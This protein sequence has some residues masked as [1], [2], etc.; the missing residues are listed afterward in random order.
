MA[1]NVIHL[2]LKIDA[3]TRD[4]KAELSRLKEILG[5]LGTGS[6]FKF[7]ARQE[8][9]E[10]S[11]AAQELQ[12]HLSVATNKFG[13]FDINR[14][15]ASLKKGEMSL[16]DMSTKLLQIGP[17]GTKAFQTLSTQIL[18]AQKPALSFSNILTKMGTT[19]A[20]NIR[21]QLSS[22]AINTVTSSIREAWTYTKNMDTALTNIRVVTGKTREDMDKLA[23]SANKMAK[24]LKS[25]TQEIVKG[26]LI[27]YQQG[28][29]D[30][31]A[32]EKARI[33][34]MAANVS[35]ESSQEEMAE[36]LT[37]IWNSYKV[38]EN[39][40][41][42]FVDKLSAV[43]ATTATSMEEI[44]TGMQKVAASGNA[45]GVT[46][47]QLNATIATIS[48][49]T[50]TSAE[51]VG[52]ALKTIY[53]RMGDLK[54]GK[55]DEDGI[56]YGQV[57][58]QVKKL[59]FDIA[60]AN[61][62]LRDM[63]EVVEEIGNKWETLSRE[64]QTALAQAIAGKR[65]YTNLFALFENWDMYLETLE[66]SKNA[67]GT[68][69]EQQDAWANSIE[70]ASNRVKASFETL[71]TQIINDD[72]IIDVMN[73]IGGFLE[74]FT[75]LI[76]ALGGLKTILPAISGLMISTFA[77]SI[78][79]GFSSAAMNLRTIFGG[80]FV[81]LQK[82]NEQLINIANTPGFSRLSAEQQ[83]LILNTKDLAIAQQ[84]YLNNS[85]HM[86]TS[87]KEEA[88]N[89]ITVAQALQEN[90]SKLESLNQAYKETALSQKTFKLAG[91]GAAEAGTLN[92]G[93]ARL[94]FNSVFKN[95]NDNSAFFSA[96]LKQQLDD[97]Q[98][99]M[100]NGVKPSVDE[101]TDAIKRYN[102]EV[103]NINVGGGGAANGVRALEEAYDKLMNK[104][105]KTLG[106]MEGYKVLATSLKA[107]SLGGFTFDT[108]D[109]A[110]A[111]QVEQ[112]LKNI[113]IEAS[114]IEQIM[115]DG[116]I[117][118]G[119]LGSDITDLKSLEVAAEKAERKLNRFAEY[120]SRKFGVSADTI[121][122]GTKAFRDKTLAVEDYQKA[123]ER[124]KGAA[125]G[126]GTGLT[127][128][129]GGITSFTSSLVSLKSAGEAIG[130]GDWLTGISSGLMG[131]TMAGSGLKSIGKGFQTM[132]GEGGEAIKGLAR[133]MNDMGLTFQKT[134]S[135]VTDTAMSSTTAWLSVLGP[136]LAVTA[137]L[138]ALG[139]VITL[140]VKDFKQA[141]TN[142][143]SAKESAKSFAEDLSNAQDSF[144]T[145]KNDLNSYNE[146]Q[147]ALSKMT[148]GTQ[149]FT[150]AVDEANN[151]VLDLMSK[152]PELAE[153]VNDANGQLSISIEGQRKLL[154]LQQKQIDQAKIN[155]LVS[156][157]TALQATQEYREQQLADKVLG[158]KATAIGS[159]VAAGTTGAAIGAAIGTAILP[160]LGTAIGA[161]LGAAGGVAAGY[162]GSGAA[163][164]R[165]HG[166]DKFTAAIEAQGTS[167]LSSYS[168]LERA[169]DGDSEL[170]RALWANKE[171]T[172]N[173]A[174]E[175]VN[176]KKQVEIN[177]KQLIA[178]NPNVKNSLFS[179]DII[180]EGSSI[181]QDKQRSQK[182]ADEMIELLNGGSEQDAADA[183]LKAMYGSEAHKYRIIDRFGTN[184]TLQK[185]NDDGVW[186]TV[187]SKSGLS[188]QTM[189]ENYRGAKAAAESL[190]QKEI[191]Q[192]T[193][194]SAALRA[195][196]LSDS[197]DEVTQAIIAQYGKDAESAIEAIKKSGKGFIEIYRETLKGQFDNTSEAW[198]EMINFELQNNIAFEG[199]AQAVKNEDTEALEKYLKLFQ[200]LG[201]F[202]GE[203]IDIFKKFNTETGKFNDEAYTEAALRRLE[204]IKQ[205]VKETSEIEFSSGFLN[206][207]GVKEKRTEDGGWEIVEGEEIVR[208]Y[209]SSYFPPEL[210]D[211]IMKE[212]LG[213]MDVGDLFTKYFTAEIEKEIEDVILNDPTAAY[214]LPTDAGTWQKEYEISAEKA[215]EYALAV[216][217]LQKVQGA[218]IKV[219][220]DGR[221]ILEKNGQQYEQNSISALAWEASI[222]KS[223][224][225]ADNFKNISSEMYNSIVS[226]GTAYGWTKGQT[227]QFLT[228]L[229]SLNGASPD[230]S[231][232]ISQCVNAGGAAMAA[233][234]SVLALHDI[235]VTSNHDPESGTTTMTVADAEGNITTYRKGTVRKLGG[236]ARSETQKEFTTRVY[237]DI[238]NKNSINP[239]DLYTDFT[240][241][242][243]DMFSKVTSPGGINPGGGGGGGKETA[244]SK[245]YK[246]A[247]KQ[248]EDEIAQAEA[249][250]KSDKDYAKYRKTVETAWAKLVGA[251]RGL[252][253]AE[254]EEAKSEMQTTSLGVREVI[255]GYF[256]N[257]AEEWK[258]GY[259]QAEDEMGSKLAG[260]IADL[261]AQAQNGL[262]TLLSTGS[263]V[264]LQ[265]A[266]DAITAKLDEDGLESSLRTYLE[267]RQTEIKNVIDGLSEEFTDY[268][269]LDFWTAQEEAMLQHDKKLTGEDWKEF[270]NAK[271]ESLREALRDGEI[272]VEEFNK[273]WNDTIS[274]G[275]YDYDLGEMVPVF[276]FDERQDLSA[277]NE[278]QKYLDETISKIDEL[279][280]LKRTLKTAMDE[281][282][283]SQTI[284]LDTFKS[285]LQIEPQYLNVLIDEHGQ[286]IKNT[287]VLDRMIMKKLQDAA[288]TQAQTY[289]NAAIAA[290]EKG[291]AEAFFN[292]PE[293]KVYESEAS[294]YS[295]LESMLLT[296][297]KGKGFT[298]DEKQQGK[299]VMKFLASAPF[300]TEIEP[301]DSSKDPNLKDFNKKKEA[302]EEAKEK[303]D[304]QL[305]MGIIDEKTYR[306]K[307]K[308]YKQDAGKAYL[309]LSETNKKENLSFA[310]SLSLSDRESSLDEFNEI[311]VD[312][313]KE[314]E[315]ATATF[316]KGSDP[317]T[318]AQEE[319]IGWDELIN[320]G[321]SQQLYHVLDKYKE[322]ANNKDLPQAEREW[323][324]R[325]YKN[326]STILSNIEKKEYR[327]TDY[328]T[329][330]KIS[331]FGEK[332]P[333]DRSSLKEA[334]KYELEELEQKY[335]K[336]DLTLTDFLTDFKEIVNE[337]Y[338]D[339]ETGKEENLFDFDER[340]ELTIERIE[341]AKQDLSEGKITVKE[342]I[343]EINELANEEYE[344]ID[345]GGMI[346]LFS[347][348]EKEDL[349]DFDEVQKRIESMIDEVN[350]LQNIKQT[351]ADAVEELNEN[352]S[353]S[354]ATF[355][356]LMK[357][358][359]KYI[360]M[361]FDEQGQLE[362]NAEAIE[363]VTK[364]RLQDI[365]VAKV[366]QYI[367]SVKQA[368]E[369]GKLEEFFNNPDNEVMD[370]ETFEDYLVQMVVD[371]LGG[372][373]SPEYL[374]ISK[375]RARNYAKFTNL[376]DVNQ[377]LKKKEKTDAENEAK[378][379]R[380]KERRILKKKYEAGEISAELY[381]SELAEITKRDKKAG[382]LTDE[383][384][385]EE[386]KNDALEYANWQKDKLLEDFEN[387]LIDYETYVKGVQDIAKRQ[388]YDYELGDY[389]PLFSK[390]ERDEI[391]KGLG[392]ES[393]EKY[394]D[395]LDFAIE[396]G[397]INTAEALAEMWRILEDA[398]LT[399]AEREELIGKVTDTLDAGLESTIDL[400]E[401][402]VYSYQ[403]ASQK[404]Q[405][406]F[407]KGWNLE[408]IDASNWDSLGDTFEKTIEMQE[409]YI[410][411][412]TSLLES[413]D[414]LWEQGLLSFKDGMDANLYYIEKWG[415]ALTDA[416]K[417][418]YSNTEK[419]LEKYIDAQIA[420][421]E[422]GAQSLFDTI[423]NIQ[424]NMSYDPELVKDKTKEVLDPVL[425]EIFEDFDEGK[426]GTVAEA[427]EKMVT[428][429]IESGYTD[430]EEINK[431]LAE[432]FAKLYEHNLQSIQNKYSAIELS[433]G[434]ADYGMFSADLNGD[435][436][437]TEEEYR[438]E[439]WQNKMA[440]LLAL[441]DSFEANYK[442]TE[443]I[444]YDKTYQ[445]ILSAID[446]EQKAGE[447]LADAALQVRKDYL[448]RQKR[449]GNMTIDDE[450]NYLNQT[451]WMYDNNAFREY[452][453][454]EEDFLEWSR[455]NRLENWEAQVAAH[456][457][458]AEL[459][460]QQLIEEYQTEKNLIEKQKQLQETNFSSIMTLRQAQH[461]INK[462]LQN[463]LSMYEYLDE[464]TRKLIFNEE[465]Y[466][467][468]SNEILRIQDEI[469]DLTAD[470][471]EKILG[472][473]EEEMEILTK[474]YEAQ[475]ALKMKEYD[476]A[477]ANLEVTKKQMALQNTLNERNTR[478]FINGQW[479]WV[480]NPE[481]V[482]KAREEILEAE[483][484][485]ETEKLNLDHQKQMNVLDD[486]VNALDR[487]INDV[488]TRFKELKET[489]KGEDGG[490][491]ATL[492]E[493][494]IAL[495]AWTDKYGEGGDIKPGTGFGK[496]GHE[497]RD[498]Q[499]GTTVRSTIV[500][501]LKDI[502]NDGKS[503]PIGTII[504]GKN[505]TFV[506][507]AEGWA[508]YSEEIDPNTGMSIGKVKGATGKAKLYSD[509]YVK[510]S[511]LKNI[512]SMTDEE[513]ISFYN[514]FFGRT[515]N[516]DDNQPY[517]EASKYSKPYENDVTNYLQDI[518]NILLSLDS[519]NID[520]LKAYK[521]AID[522]AKN[523]AGAV[524][525]IGGKNFVSQG[526]GNFYSPDAD[527][528]FTAEEI[529][530][531]IDANITILRGTQGTEEAQWG[532]EKENYFPK[533]T[534]EEE[535]STKFPFVR[536]GEKFNSNEETSIPISLTD[537]D[538]NG[539]LATFDETVSDSITTTGASIVTAIEETGED[540]D[541]ITPDQNAYGNIINRPTLSWVGEDGPEAII[542]LSQKY[543]SRGLSL[544]EEATKALG[545]TPSFTM[546][547]IRASFPQQK[548]N[549]NVSQTIN[550]TVQ[551][552]DS[553]NDFYAITNLL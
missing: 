430:M 377:D 386:L 19:L 308:P 155:S 25:T 328:T 466:V 77:P 329:G 540:G 473:S 154:E 405:E 239:K 92:Y 331:I 297:W 91:N 256:D 142:M 349:K 112:A 304:Y 99:K 528:M 299:G 279:V 164:K 265:A 316:G 419:Q 22:A 162:F 50:R 383:E 126:F 447:Q 31:L 305:Q 406:M 253:E 518:I 472:A 55:T 173:L 465:D 434:V 295:F 1:N 184:S 481:S 362:L 48:S 451:Q 72:A 387:G 269:I 551:N 121:K 384:A 135:L 46:Y 117:P 480:A 156:K 433:Q 165:E 222:N 476:I 196:I 242:W 232:F 106:I 179:S 499:N 69:Q 176:N 84:E 98:T 244:A 129:V 396:Q 217:D 458:K 361:L 185:Q 301:I 144:N 223:I 285:L 17:D 271:L 464:E 109:I 538:N 114:V 86:T 515:Y 441:K 510:S 310:H 462:E 157:N 42:L 509:S 344:D 397:G 424:N 429:I 550:V 219:A 524:V 228:S 302:Y 170:A 423:A 455:K 119:V 195:K 313:R 88:Q 496:E 180:N 167:I 541:D 512:N 516:P 532:L 85:R 159:S 542:P 408:S 64:E 287:E 452:F 314:G 53:A 375:T 291:E 392:K 87:Q 115:R 215:K 371:D 388:Y 8:I 393:I 66:T 255:V 294:L 482:A 147:S 151:Q 146:K 62:Q 454:N 457:R 390:E 527:K 507:T 374:E 75:G 381:Y 214:S 274:K 275:Y 553:S 306:E 453:A 205:K 467:A 435:G 448:D 276:S 182:Y 243:T 484:N 317:Y 321:S 533:K 529:I 263:S 368:H 257:I 548:E 143:K 504:K 67:M 338:K 497:A 260:S 227:N 190:T 425:A 34:T 347:D 422:K 389:L 261:E 500:S 123:L 413:T 47:D 39:Q 333:I 495:A 102:S 350:E 81:D 398:T 323:N 83:K 187:G 468:L 110:V 326:L 210:I 288:I 293:S 420:L 44:A 89:A 353:I 240:S 6:G 130:Q 246:A 30:K 124:A 166:L 168:S 218:Q 28:D 188:D 76:E 506:N 216:Q 202:I 237:K 400:A 120:G 517:T 543:R 292:S 442:G 486:S 478:M 446:A 161:A 319:S 471:N 395:S 2:G 103:R 150:D 348:E 15:T 502:L 372:W 209:L 207:E 14:F 539:K 96:G 421:Y 352:N 148:K 262:M 485:A 32:A 264:D 258:E 508:E 521:T 427:A 437:F 513:L 469:N 79:S 403:E 94:T 536:T 37:A 140:V 531:K 273:E 526:D 141:E 231:G 192:I 12:K 490:V 277:F 248:Y 250:F 436:L 51:Q 68:L 479:T 483:Y 268:D 330:N 254:K 125:A 351:L 325:Q 107:N 127:K 259:K 220:E 519:T 234:N 82:S 212:Y 134:G 280:G 364:K 178:N 33:A 191:A 514:D 56:T 523:T 132:H 128:A 358:E 213:G 199:L 35:F 535:K 201:F 175:I 41:E 200:E 359:P 354:V 505:K 444:I 534:E 252:S 363:Q 29:S 11:I 186:E 432:Q 36:Y 373:V 43:G 229:N 172:N 503:V 230:L 546:P 5:Q 21:W 152:Y 410:E 61:G 346:P 307:M 45:V 52:T 80:W 208:S 206:L 57:S 416:Q 203:D 113:G 428:A 378:E 488:E 356:E 267:R 3:D 122:S 58:A 247:K 74:Y 198:Q 224:L 401:K 399:E 197:K 380:E 241:E 13:D 105:S 27:F 394:F 522:N 278:L 324:E 118:D 311:V 97:L 73:G 245:A 225:A 470:Y 4:A 266:Y 376:T 290:K 171:E 402:G 501:E 233:L 181:L 160:G 489:L 367:Q 108:K 379:A 475:V 71:Y 38:G 463:S 443:A 204:K 365:A 450:I 183:Y 417:N 366:Q 492:D 226:V 438:L 300:S 289:I 477:K 235:T 303:Y 26:Q 249:E 145:L 270:F 283:E 320:N 404:M 193:E 322:N 334:R 414:S 547:T 439:L 520:V 370:P 286:I 525:R 342:Y 411:Y 327:A 456:E 153:Y 138:V 189:I 343:D 440:E 345:L 139:A 9:R 409:K 498:K 487:Q 90:I 461:D 163:N 78:V 357:L 415:I 407:L 549:M 149:E 238:I 95:V 272:S 312:R 60:N 460:K 131:L 449:L 385:S 491:I 426:I 236:Y 537:L 101:L 40:L 544:W 111:K 445:S 7:N 194:K 133:S 355:G 18:N 412:A 136:I 493:F 494:D 431:I 511:V 284:S 530:G 211:Q 382:I 340:K 336:G 298:W 23:I 59:G 116:V 369:E 10:A 63:G 93:S 177:T 545:I 251:F 54:A 418:I 24:E 315:K 49:T 318:L 104:M 474:E 221:I 341:Q 337:K 360:D 552:E 309:K 174:K 332:N 281:L 282:N 70:G 459:I 137:A 391:E 296:Q 339:P 20:N 169:L 158:T 335:S 100:K 65:Q 16:A